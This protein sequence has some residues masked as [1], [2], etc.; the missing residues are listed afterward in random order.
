MVRFS[1]SSLERGEGFAA[2][3]GLGGDAMIRFGDSKCY[4]VKGA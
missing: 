4:V 3:V 1:M 2:G